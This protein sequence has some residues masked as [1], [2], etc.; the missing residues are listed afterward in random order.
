KAKAST[1]PNTRYGEGPW[2][3]VH[4]GAVHRGDHRRRPRAHRRGLADLD[5]A[6]ERGRA[7]LRRQPVPQGDPGLLLER[8][9]A[10]VSALARG[11]PQG[12]A[13]A[14]HRA[15]PAQALPRP[16]HRQGFRA[17]QGDRRRH[18]RRA[19]RVRGS[20]DQA[21]ELQAARPHLRRRAEVLRLEI[22]LPARGGEARRGGEAGGAVDAG[23][24]GG[25]AAGEVTYGLTASSTSRLA[26]P[27][28][29][30]RKFLIDLTVYEGQ[31]PG[32]HR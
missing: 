17:G 12:P 27:T 6:R 26:P 32:T 10:P 30:V 16:D 15:L 29:S 22:H 5:D 18:P 9:A 14:R 28:P 4:D 8:A 21:G 24:T 1:A 19:K 23:T 2:L 20:A 25:A 7:P 31:P 13:P 3:H 11:S